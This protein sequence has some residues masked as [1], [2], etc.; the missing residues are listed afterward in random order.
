MIKTKMKLIS[1][2]VLLTKALD[3]NPLNIYVVDWEFAQFSLPAFDIGQMVAELYMLDHYKSISAG[4]WLITGFMEGYG[5]IEKNLAYQVAIH[6]GVHI[7]VWGNRTP[8]Y[9]NSLSLVF[10]IFSFSDGSR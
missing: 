3:T 10:W 8:G 5:E 1:Y 2:S 6:A 9:V 4:V 7:I